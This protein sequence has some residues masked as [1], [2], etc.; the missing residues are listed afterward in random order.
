MRNT[1]LNNPIAFGGENGLSELLLAILNVLIIISVPFMVFFL[2]YAGFSYVTARGNPDGIKKATN[3][4]I[5]AIIGA[6]IIIG[7]SAIM[8]IIRNVAESF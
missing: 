7:S 1:S 8:A 2:I 4:L 3:S 5:Y 6:V